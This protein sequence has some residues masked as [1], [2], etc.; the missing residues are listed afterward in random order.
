MGEL[1]A[2]LEQ[3][4]GGDLR[5]IEKRPITVCVVDDHEL[6]RAGTR[7]I[8]ES[9]GTF[10]VV[11]EA[12]DAKSALE[13]IAVMHPSVAL[14]DISIG[15]FNGI[16]LA[17]RIKEQ[18][19]S[20][21]VVILS[22]YD[23]DDYVHAALAAGVRGYLLKTQPGEE[24]TRA[25]EAASK[26]MTVLD[27]AVM[28][29]LAN[30]SPKNDPLSELTSRE[31]DVLAYLAHGCANK[32]IATELGISLR[33]VEGHISHIFEKTG[34][35]SRTELALLA[36]KHGLADRVSPGGGHL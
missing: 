29:K 4:F 27:P 2:S 3:G 1:G 13:A 21:A 11:L 34:T 16:E 32:K 17:R 24:L 7:Q 6:I 35:I 9:N 18:S 15:P 23:D 8:L 5:V 22:A 25:V 28:A 12:G 19:P 10:E 36:A 26:G 20:T 33:T 30:R 31:L 14:V